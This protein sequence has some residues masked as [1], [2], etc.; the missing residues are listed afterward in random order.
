V[1]KGRLNQMLTAEALYQEAMRLK[2]DRDAEV[3]RKIRQII[4]QRLLEDNVTKP[5]EQWKISEKELQAYYDANKDK[6]YR[7]E[8]VRIAD[9]FISVSK[10]ASNKEREEKRRLA[11]Q[12][13]KKAMD[14]KA[15]RF[16]FSQLIR[17]YSDRPKGYRK[18]DTGFFDSQGRPA[19]IDSSL[20]AASFGLKKIGEIADRVIETR[21][22]FHVIMLVGRRSEVKRDLKDLA[23]M[24]KRRMKRE[25]LERRRKAFIDEVRAK[26]GIE[27]N[28]KAFAQLIKEMGKVGVSSK[29]EGPPTLP[30]HR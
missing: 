21:D 20:V 24:L 5:V 15:R 18:G 23:P 13:L 14:G 7:P 22:G 10:V 30:G 6:Y 1:A 17:N 28:E 9:I 16:S 26:S 29:G 2:L 25:E 12:V 8:Q 11:E 3:K 27:I 4:V 19:G